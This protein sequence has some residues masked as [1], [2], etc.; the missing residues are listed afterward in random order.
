MKYIYF[1]LHCRKPF[2][3]QKEKLSCR[4]L[5]VMSKNVP[6]ISFYR[7]LMNSAEAYVYR[8]LELL[9]LVSYM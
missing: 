2:Q 4:Y 6:N 7:R 5:L 9:A 1:W 3:L 8:N